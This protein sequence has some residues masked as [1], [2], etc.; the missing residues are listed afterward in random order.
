[1]N[2]LRL[3]H[4]L[5]LAALLLGCSSLHEC[6]EEQLLEVRSPSG[7][8]TAVLFARNCGATT[9]YVYHVNLKSASNVFSKDW[10][11]TIHEG[12]VF[13]IAQKVPELTWESETKLLIQCPSCTP[14]KPVHLV[15]AWNQ[16]EITYESGK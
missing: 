2:S 9:S 1:M 3:S 7:R 4:I 10:N 15:K 14:S 5:L 6:S 12:E 11:G 16:V 8:H 13:V